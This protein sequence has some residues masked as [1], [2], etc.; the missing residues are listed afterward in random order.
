MHY[1]ERLT[2][3]GGLL[4]RVAQGIEGGRPEHGQVHLAADRLQP[5]QQRP[6]HHLI[7]HVIGPGRPGYH[8]QHPQPAARHLQCRRVA[9]AGKAP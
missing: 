6:G 4:H 5:F 9:C 7:A 3:L 8:H 1:V 2:I